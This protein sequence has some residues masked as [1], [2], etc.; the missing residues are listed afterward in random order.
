MPFDRR[1]GGSQMMMRG[2]TFWGAIGRQENDLWLRLNELVGTIPINY[3]A[4]ANLSITWTP[5]MGGGLGQ[6][7]ALGLQN[8]AYDLDGATSLIAITN[9][10]AAANLTIAKT[11]RWAFLAKADGLGES[12]NGTFAAWGNTSTVNH[13]ILRF[14]SNNCLEAYIRTNGTHARILTDNNEIQD[15]LTNFAWYFVDYD[16]TNI[17]GNGRVMRAYKGLSGQSVSELSLAVQDAATGT[18][19]D[20]VADL[21][22]GNISSAAQTFDGLLD[23]ALCK[24]G[25]LWTLAEMQK[26][27]DFLP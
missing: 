27:T 9:N 1:R 26:M 18:V 13:T 4:L 15:C 3:G 5:G 14:Q 8:E 23:E 22:I 25:S 20:Q 7:G 12:S 10:A 17:L 19:T 11:Q 21:N 2:D 16:D 6:V 24:I